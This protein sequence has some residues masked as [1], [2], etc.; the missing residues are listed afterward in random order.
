M[1]SIGARALW[2]IGARA[3][4]SIGAR[5][6][7]CLF[8]EFTVRVLTLAAVMQCGV[9]WVSMKLIV[10]RLFFREH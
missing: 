4:W 8:A 2:S 10:A 3:L 7:G 1:G 6:C 9:K 5:A